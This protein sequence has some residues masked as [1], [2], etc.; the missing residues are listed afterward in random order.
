MKRQTSLA[1]HS[2]DVCVNGCKL[3]NLEDDQASC[4]Y[5][6]SERF[7]MTYPTKPLSTMKIMSLGDIIS[8][9]IANPDT[10]EELK[11][12]HQYD[13]RTNAQS[14]VIA[15]FF[16]GEE[17]KA[18]KNN[19]NFQSEYDIAIA[20]FND[21]FVTEKRGDRLFT[22]IHVVILSYNPQLRYKEEYLVQLCILPGKKKPVSF[23]S[24]L[25]VILAEIHYLST[26][27][28]VVKTA[29]NQIIRSKVHC[30]A[31]GGDTLGESH[32]LKF[33]WIG[34]TKFK[35]NVKVFLNFLELLTIRLF[36]AVVS[37]ILVASIRIIVHMVFTSQTLML[38]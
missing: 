33:R 31:F 4:A 37:A 1:A 2:Y 15:D 9:L 28:M 5:C 30:L 14:G 13:N 7:D 29:D 10:R 32:F 17:Y 6:N 21:G 19:H 23:S 26:Y 8:R 36:W 34:S 35:S 20:L 25:S 3:Y 12:R 38:L 22:M 11:Y 16:D 24:Y 18:F 27:G